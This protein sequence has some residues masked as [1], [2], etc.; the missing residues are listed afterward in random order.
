MWFIWLIMANVVGRWWDNAAIRWVSDRTGTLITLIRAYPSTWRHY[1][2]WSSPYNPGSSPR[3]QLSLNP[4][5]ILFDHHHVRW[6]SSWIIPDGMPSI[7]IIF[8]PPENN[9]QIS[10]LMTNAQH[11]WDLK[12]HPI[13]QKFIKNDHRQNKTTDW[14][15]HQPVSTIM[16]CYSTSQ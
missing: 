7:L 15:D 10:R 3:I 1:L 6:S 8:D 16:N 12:Y 5:I 4:L 2:W 14:I 13:T 9:P 11:I